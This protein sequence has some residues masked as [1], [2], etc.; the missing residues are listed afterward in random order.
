MRILA[1]AFPTNQSPAATSI[2]S[3]LNEYGCTL[4]DIMGNREKMTRPAPNAPL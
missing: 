4:V 2:G 1:A 3:P